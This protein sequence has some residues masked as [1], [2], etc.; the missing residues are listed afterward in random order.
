ME[1]SKVLENIDLK[2]ISQ[3]EALKLMEINAEAVFNNTLMS[4][5][6]GIVIGSN[7]GIKLKSDFN[8]L[9]LRIDAALEGEC[10]A[11]KLRVH[12]TI[13]DM[14]IITKPA[15]L[16][17]KILKFLPVELIQDRDLVVTIH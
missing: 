13:G 7:A 10:V 8:E 9:H 2:T 17:K 1:L 6:N 11:L 16:A 12:H 4:K 3:K 14:N 5:N 15:L